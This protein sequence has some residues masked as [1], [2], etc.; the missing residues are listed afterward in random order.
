MGVTNAPMK[1]ATGDNSSSGRRDHWHSSDNVATA[2]SVQQKPFRRYWLAATYSGLVSNHTANQYN[3]DLSVRMRPKKC[4]AI[5]V[6]DSDT[7][8]MNTISQSIA[9]S[10]AKHIK[11]TACTSFNNQSGFECASRSSRSESA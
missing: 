1:I 8:G 9:T 6:A 3:A 2:R 11:F 5:E 4:P 7:G 10:E